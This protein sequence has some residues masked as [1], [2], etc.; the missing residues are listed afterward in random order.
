MNKEKE[1]FFDETIK[2]CMG[3]IGT[4]LPTLNKIIMEFKELYRDTCKTN[5]MTID[6]DKEIN[7]VQK[8][9]D[10]IVDNLIGSFEPLSVTEQEI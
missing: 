6:I 2:K 4:L 10:N 3:H 8:E 9:I 5:I 7:K 1:K